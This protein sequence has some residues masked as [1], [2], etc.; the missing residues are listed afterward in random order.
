M[1]VVLRAGSEIYLITKGADMVMEPLLTEPLSENYQQHLRDYSQSG[2]RTLVIAYKKVDRQDFRQWEKDYTEAQNIID[3]TKEECVMELQA[4]LEQDLKVLGITAVEDCLQDGVPEAIATIKQAG[5]RVWVL[6]GD[7]TETA[8]DIAR[9]CQLF[10]DSTTLAYA[11]DATS[12][13]IALAKLKAAQQM[14]ERCDNGGL[15]LDGRTMQYCLLDDE[16][17][18]LIFDLGIASRSC[19][20][21]R[22]TPLQKRNLVDIVRHRDSRTI[23][24]AIGDGANDVPMISGAHLGIAVRGKE[25]NQAVQVSD[26][27]ISQ[28]RFL[29]PLLLCH[30]RRAY[31]RVALYLCYYLYK[32]VCLL[33]G[34]VV[35]MFMDNYRG[36]IAFPE[37][38]SINYNVFFTSW[39]I[40]FVLGFDTDVSDT[41]ANSHPELYLVGPQRKLFNKKI[42]T[43]WIVCA[44]YHGVSAWYAASHFVID[45]AAYDK[46]EPGQF[47]EGSVTAF[48][49][50]ILIVCLKLLLHCQSPLALRTSILPTL[51]AILCYFGI[52]GA[53]AYVPPGPSL[54]PSVTGLPADLMQNF[55]A[56]IVMVAAPCGIIMP[57]VIFFVIR[58]MIW[59]TPLE[60]V[61][62]KIKKGEIQIG[63]ENQAHRKDLDD[64]H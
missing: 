52:L 7:K 37:Y 2:L 36:R 43:G 9:S 8:V 31:R 35:W 12:I 11:T 51:G 41:V 25:G 50:I 61:R 58:Y 5:I 63:T 32:N 17:K 59:P 15:V 55:T 27:A 48:T 33:M 23:T 3:E 24:L 64:D 62:A 56:L 14:L 53:L 60:K 28:F 10:T 39:H 21:C 40:L 26:V 46:T 57:D 4:Q 44:V 16:C 34:D 6:T 18:Q 13:E 42:F 29:V 49:I 45:G 47:W 30:G 1:S 20:C 38:L 22:L 19:V 54:Q